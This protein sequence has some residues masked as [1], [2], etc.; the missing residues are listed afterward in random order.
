MYLIKKLWIDHTENH[1]SNACGYKSMGYVKTEKEA[2]KICNSEFID[3]SKYP[4]PLDYIHYDGF[5]GDEIPVYIYEKLE[6]F[7]FGKEIE[8]KVTKEGKN[9]IRQIR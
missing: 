9:A 7:R 2:Q 5:K 8:D 6:Y 3:K 1:F 4:W